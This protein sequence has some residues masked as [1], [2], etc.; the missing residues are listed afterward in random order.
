MNLRE[1]PVRGR[2]FAA[3]GPEH[4]AVSASRGPDRVEKGRNG[5]MLPFPVPDPASG[6]HP[7]LEGLILTH[8]GI[9]RI[10]SGDQ[11]D[12]GRIGQGGENGL[13]LPAEASFPEHPRQ[14]AVLP[15]KTEVRVKKSIQGNQNGLSHSVYLLSFQ[16]GYMIP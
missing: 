5:D 14:P 3:D 10:A 12:M 11:G 1:A 7:G 2:V 9:R 8:P 15:Q 4:G 6:G 16:I 13:H